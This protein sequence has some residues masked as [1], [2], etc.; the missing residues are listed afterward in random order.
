MEAT[1]PAQR[2]PA[3]T[4]AFF[5]GT[6]TPQCGGVR[7]KLGGMVYEQIIK[8]KKTFL[9]NPSNT[10]TNLCFSMCLAR[11]MHP[12]ITV[13][14]VQIH[15]QQIHTRAGFNSNHKVSLGDVSIFEQQLGVKIFVFHHNHGTKKLDLF[16]THEQPR[17][18]TVWL[19]LNDDHYYM[20]Q[21]KTGFFGS[22]YVCEFCYKGYKSH[23]FHKC[24]YFCNVC[25]SSTCYNHQNTTN[26]RCS[27][28]LRLCRSEFCF[29]KHKEMTVQTQR[30]KSFRPCD[31]TKYCEDCGRLYAVTGRPNNIRKCLKG[32]CGHCGEPLTS[33]TTHKCYIQPQKSSDPQTKYVF[34][35]FETSAESGKH[36][37]NF[38]CAI[39]FENKWCASRSSCV[40]LFVHTFRQPKYRNYTFIAHNASGFDNYILLDYFTKQGIVPR[41][42]MRGSKVLLMYDNQLKQRWLDSYS[43]IPMRLAKTPAALGFEDSKK[44][45][46]PHMFNI[47]ENADYVGPY[48]S[49]HY[50]GYD[51]MSEKD[52]V[53]FLQWYNTVRHDV[54]D[55]Q[56]ELRSY[57]VN[58][59]V[60]LRK[61]CVVYRD[62]FIECAGLDPFECTTLAS[63][64]M[65]VFKTQFLPPDTLALTHD[66]AYTNQ[67]KTFSNASI[68][69]LEFEAFKNDA[70]IMH[71]LNHGEKQFGPYHVDVFCEWGGVRT[72]YEFAGC[73]W[74]G[75]PKCHS[76][77][78][79]NAVNNIAFGVLYRQFKEKLASLRQ[80]HK[81][82]VRVMWEC[83]WEQAKTTDQTLQDFLK[84]YNAPERLNPRH[85]LFGG[86]TN[87]YKLHC[88]VAEGEKIQY[89]DFTS[90]YPTVQAQK[91]YPIGHPKIIF[92]DFEAI[93]KYFGLIK[94]S[95][96]TPRVVSS[97]V[98]IPM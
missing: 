3:E 60:V 58:D 8:K 95:V 83:E 68:Q 43:F 21:N 14:E 70:D 87:A 90:L 66:G 33:D 80:T 29:K 44:G 79:K 22:D 81:L 24:K 27:D 86:R 19:Y 30:R 13:D 49:P 78:H 53:E 4:S 52:R 77:G 64:C 41:L 47:T 84:N 74:H 35:D 28:C 97:R 82:H 18:N 54:F 11:H 48:P 93:D 45:Y 2:H 89:Y 69:W 25:L 63:C 85:A 56:S 5:P 37:A 75:C 94:C 96:T 46:F 57:G 23:A 92:R 51:N 17:T 67:Y 34:Y 36:K 72:A 10:D 40:K 31:S 26:I 88:K 98:A 76:P 39:D 71:A 1:P 9:Y 38:V 15:A 55:F 65:S 6:Q 61:A 91:S 50:Y 12:Q 73:F 42:T 20:I 59:V 7:R 16:Q 62:A 32:K